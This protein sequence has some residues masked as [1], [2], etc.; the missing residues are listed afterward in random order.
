[1]PIHY[2]LEPRLILPGRRKG[3]WGIA[4]GTECNMPKAA[5]LAILQR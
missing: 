5:K 3:C 4:A 1:M 2:F